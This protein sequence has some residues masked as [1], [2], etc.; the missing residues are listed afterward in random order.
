MHSKLLL[1]LVLGILMAGGA[2]H[3]QMLASDHEPI[4][5][6]AT[7]EGK[8]V[9]IKPDGTKLF[10]DSEGSSV[11]IDPDGK[12][13]IKQADGTWIQIKPDGSKTIK[14]PDGSTVE[15]KPGK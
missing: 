1:N 9:Q 8:S 13:T 7:D 3:S 11:Q 15:I 6:N 5:I 10:K 2:L 14:K 12:K 4:A